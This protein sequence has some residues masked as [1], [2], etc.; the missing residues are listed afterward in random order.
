MSIANRDYSLVLREKH[1]NPNALV[2]LAK[3]KRNEVIC[4]LINLQPIDTRHLY[5][6]T[7]EYSQY[8]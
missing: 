1:P 4:D 7:T 5:R 8:T 6:A 2:L 3:K